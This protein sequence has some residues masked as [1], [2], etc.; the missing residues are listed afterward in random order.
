MLEPGVLGDDVLYAEPSKPVAGMRREVAGGYARLLGRA[1]PLRERG[2]DFATNCVLTA[3]A[4]DLALAEGAGVQAGAAGLLE[5]G[6]AGRSGG[7]TEEEAGVGGGGGGGGVVCGDGQAGRVAMLPADPA[8]VRLVLTAADGVGGEERPALQ[9]AASQPA[10]A[11]LESASAAAT[12]S[13][14]AS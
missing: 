9:P 8:M 2:G 4:V 11:A 10:P 12:R 7:A 5:V 13:G 3:I 14:D 6:E 1:N